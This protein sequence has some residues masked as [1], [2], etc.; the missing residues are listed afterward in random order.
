MRSNIAIAPRD[1]SPDP[2][3]ARPRPGFGPRPRDADD[4]AVVVP[5][6]RASVGGA[7]DQVQQREAMRR[8]LVRMREAAGFNQTALAARLGITQ[9]EVSKF[10]RGERCLDVLRL[11]AWLH[12]LEMS[13]RRFADALERELDRPKS[14]ADRR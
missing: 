12:C 1:C 3:F 10:E 14:L 9:S 6:G 7:T 8:V 11:R 2:D 13:F 4:I 5:L